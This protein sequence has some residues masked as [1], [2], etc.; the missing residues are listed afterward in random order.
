MSAEDG[1]M[2]ESLDETVLSPSG[3]E[4][5]TIRCREGIP[6]LTAPRIDVEEET[7]SVKMA[8]SAIHDCV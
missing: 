4:S 5:V 6:Y 7:R 3:Q 1:A 8:R 2:K